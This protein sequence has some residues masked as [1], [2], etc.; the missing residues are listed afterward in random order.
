MNR[1]LQPSL[2]NLF[3]EIKL[4][5]KQKNKKI[6]FFIS[7]T[8]K[9]SPYSFI[10]LP[11]RETEKV[12]FGGITVYDLKIAYK[13]VDFLEKKIDLILIDSESKIKG[14][15]KLSEKLSA[16][17]KHCH[18]FTFKNNDITADAAYYLI[19]QFYFPLSKKTIS[20]LGT[21]NIG[22]KLALK[23]IES[24]SNVR[25]AGLNFKTTK[26]I[27]NA[28]NLLKTKNSLKKVVAKS[29]TNVARDSEILVGIT[30]G[31]PIIDDMMV[32]EMN[33]NGMIIDVGGGTIFSSGIKAAN[34]RKIKIIKLDIRNSFSGSVNTAMSTKKFLVDDFGDK[35]INDVRVVA[36]GLY[37]NSGDII[38]DK[39]KKPTKIIGISDGMGGLIQNKF[40]SN[41]QEKIKIVKKTIDK[42]K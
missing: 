34:K 19:S 6:G 16:K 20:I 1:K 3:E 31:I 15:Q 36:G 10:T 22:S 32:N 30:P 35:M 40:S 29:K 11:I 24:E 39:I 8:S 28:I 9:R 12:L 25:I 18:V 37:G 42:K 26:K 14:L 17:I 2:N 4:R 38:V 27:A 41:I 5:A 23:L 21:G 13:I 7:T 33:K